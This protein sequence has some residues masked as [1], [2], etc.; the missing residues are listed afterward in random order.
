MWWWWF[1][2]CDEIEALIAVEERV[3][4]LFYS[5]RQT[6]MH[7]DT[8]TLL[9]AAGCT[10]LAQAPDAKPL[11]PLEDRLPQDEIIYF[12]MPD[13]FENGDPSNDRGGISGDR[14]DHG[15]ERRRRVGRVLYEL[16]GLEPRPH[17]RLHGDDGPAL[18]GPG[19]P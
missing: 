7:L 4:G 6:P 17:G 10:S 5:T 19:R 13:R 2:W 1:G 12:V 15:F 16:D 8:A 18:R 14:L 11:P 3:D 9:A